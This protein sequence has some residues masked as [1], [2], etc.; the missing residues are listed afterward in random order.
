[1]LDGRMSAGALVAFM[2]YVASLNGAF[3]VGRWRPCLQRLL[4]QELHLQRLCKTRLV[5][6]GRQMKSTCKTSRFFMA[7]PAVYRLRKWPRRRAQGP[8]YAV[9]TLGSCLLQH[10][11]RCWRRLA[12]QGMP[13]A[14]SL[15]RKST[16][17]LQLARR[18]LGMCSQPLQ[19]RW[20]RLTRWWS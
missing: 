9:K 3:Q 12:G 1:V 2:L 20:G 10:L 17:G 15:Q 6:G 4:L 19:R 18:L 11:L 16:E 8:H 5:V 7:F 14:L 13:P